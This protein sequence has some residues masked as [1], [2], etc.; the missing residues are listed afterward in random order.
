MGQCRTVKEYL[1]R[2]AQVDAAL[3]RAGIKV[4]PNPYRTEE[5]ERLSHLEE[6]P[7]TA[8]RDHESYNSLCAHSVDR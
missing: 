3:R 2:E 4:Y 5:L 1:A 7:Q 6:I 8:H